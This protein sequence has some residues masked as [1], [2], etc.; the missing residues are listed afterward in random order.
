MAESGVH[1]FV[2]ALRSR[3]TSAS[4]R[5]ASRYSAARSPC[6][7]SQ[8]SQISSSEAEAAASKKSMEPTR[9]AMKGSMKLATRKS[10]LKAAYSS[11]QPWCI[12]LARRQMSLTIRLSSEAPRR[13][14]EAPAFIFPRPLFVSCIFALCSWTRFLCCWMS[15]SSLCELTRVLSAARSFCLAVARSAA[16]TSTQRFT[17]CR[18]SSPS[19][20]GC[21]RLTL[22][23]MTSASVPRSSIVDTSFACGPRMSMMTCFCGG[24]CVSASSPTT[25]RTSFLPLPPLFFHPWLLSTCFSMLLLALWRF[26]R[27]RRERSSS[28]SL[29]SSRRPSLSSSSSSSSPSSAPSAA[30]ALL[31]PSS[32]SSFW[33][34]LILVA[35]LKPP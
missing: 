25:K 3:G 2:R 11:G 29:L 12:V 18:S 26:R 23:S 6:S 8:T 27:R 16:R 13:S 31:W 5:M 32:R 21:W 30:S 20:G 34:A 28:S 22:S 35:S 1:E 19:L 17:L 7:G 4:A 9:R 10:I 14:S 33:L 15:C 24:S